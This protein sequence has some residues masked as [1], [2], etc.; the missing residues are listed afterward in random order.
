MERIV[1]NL[2]VTAL[3]A[4]AVMMLLMGESPCVQLC[5][6]AY[7]IFLAYLAKKTPK[8]R[9]ILLRLLK[10]ADETDNYLKGKRNLE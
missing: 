2:K 7:S 10:Q 1:F 4:P 5:G 9:N 6:L 8:G 3:V